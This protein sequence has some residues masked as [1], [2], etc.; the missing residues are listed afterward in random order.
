MKIMAVSLLLRRLFFS[1]FQRIAVGFKSDVSNVVL[2]YS[3]N[4]LSLS[5]VFCRSCGPWPFFSFL[6]L[7]TVGRTPRTGDQPSLGRYLH[8]EQHKYRIKAHRH[9]CL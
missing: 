1:Q 3:W 2:I 4:I 9:P 5:S 7:Y 6:I 8:T